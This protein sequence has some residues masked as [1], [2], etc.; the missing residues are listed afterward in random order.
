[1]RSSFSRGTCVN[2]GNGYSDFK[3][4]TPSHLS[5]LGNWSAVAVVSLRNSTAVPLKNASVCQESVIVRSASFISPS[6]RLGIR[7]YSS[8]SLCRLSFRASLQFFVLRSGLLCAQLTAPEDNAG[9]LTRVLPSTS[10]STTSR[11]G[12]GDTSFSNETS[13]SQVLLPQV[14]RR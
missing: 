13:Y 4:G 10:R 12:R 6:S 14:F 3:G 9:T 2:R 5:E 7:L 8:F 1:M 11:C